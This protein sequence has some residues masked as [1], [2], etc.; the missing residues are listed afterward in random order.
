MKAL[1]KH[2]NKAWDFLIWPTFMV[3]LSLMT[4]VSV[5]LMTKQLNY[6]FELISWAIPGVHAFIWVILTSFLVWIFRGDIQ[7][8]D[9]KQNI[10][11]LL[12][13]RAYFCLGIAYFCTVKIMA[14][15]I[16]FCYRSL[17]IDKSA[18]ILWIT[19]SAF[20]M[21]IFGKYFIPNY[22]K[23]N[24]LDDEEPTQPLVRLVV[25]T[26]LLVFLTITPLWI[27]L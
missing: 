24:T 18:F 22:V 6:N 19:V 23:D 1:W 2:L 5:W 14:A 11:E 4:L 15:N 26:L 20:F 27:F 10:T 7:S 9:H 21:I 8:S 13:E 3:F 12:F 16:F 25:S 17:E